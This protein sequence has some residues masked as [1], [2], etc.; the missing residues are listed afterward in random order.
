MEYITLRTP[1]LSALSD[2]VKNLLIKLG[3][4][5]IRFAP[6]FLNNQTKILS[7][8]RGAK[9]EEDLYDVLSELRCASFLLTL[10]EVTEL[11]YEPL[12]QVQRSPDFKV[13]T[14]TDGEVYFEVRRIRKNLSEFKRDEFTE[15]FWIKAKQNIR[16]N[17]G[18][19]LNTSAIEEAELFEQ[20]IRKIDEIIS[21]IDSVLSELSEDIEESIELTLDEF[22]DGLKINISSIPEE[23]RIY[24]E[25]RKYGVLFKTPYSGNEDRKFGDIIFEKTRQLLEGE[26]NVIFIYADN[27]THEVYDMMDSIHLINQLLREANEEIIQKKGYVSVKDFLIKSQRISGIFLLTSDQER[28]YWNNRNSLLT[29]DHKLIKE[30]EGSS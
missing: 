20:L 10:S 28:H 2:K 17:F 5:S 7:K 23:R 11:H 9:T 4:D 12:H 8:L 24:N 25:I 13:I 6:W 15:L 1:Y 18:L 27:E 26:K 29:I 30:L 19:S 21:H 22:A 14:K 3:R 16:R